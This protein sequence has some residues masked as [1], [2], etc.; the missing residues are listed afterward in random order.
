[1]AHDPTPSYTN[2]KLELR[3]NS[4]KGGFGL[5]AREPIAK[6]EVLSVWGGEIMTGEELETQ[7]EE[8][9]KHGLQV[10][11]NM[12]LLPLVDNDPADYYNHSCDPNAGLNGQICLVAMR[13][14]AVNE[15]VCFDYAMSDGSDY[16]EFQCQCA[17][18][19]CRGTIT[20]GDWRLP[21][22]HRR[23]V[24]YFIPYLQRRIDKIYAK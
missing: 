2:P 11:E 4:R 7:P 6:D 14:I 16:D 1:M 13:D 24:G 15:E 5:Y 18:E 17:S 8:R 22:L 19:H 20:G 21:E 3:S 23:Y 10:E 9:A 12:Y